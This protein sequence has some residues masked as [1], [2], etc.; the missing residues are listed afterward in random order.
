MP[1]GNSRVYVPTLKKIALGLPVLPKVW[2]LT[3]FVDIGN[4]T[5][6]FRTRWP[7]LLG[8]LRAML[9]LLVLSA[10]VG[11]AFSAASWTD[12]LAQGILRMLSQLSLLPPFAL[13]VDLNGL[14]RT[15]ACSSSWLMHASWALL[16][17]A[18]LVLPWR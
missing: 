7:D 13:L 4:C 14:L 17:S 1:G 16:P 3:S 12:M 11:T 18:D 5:I 8:S 9:R 6:A 2:G 15:M 10:L